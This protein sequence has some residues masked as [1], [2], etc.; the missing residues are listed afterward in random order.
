VFE[1]LGGG[2]DVARLHEALRNTAPRAS[3]GAARQWPSWAIEAEDGT[4]VEEAGRFPDG[5]IERMLELAE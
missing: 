2:W 4:R 5:L 1:A 3:T